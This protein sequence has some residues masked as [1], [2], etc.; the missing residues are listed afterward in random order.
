MKVS[1]LIC[2][3]IAWF[4]SIAPSHSQ[5]FYVAENGNDDNPGTETLPWRTIQWA[6][7]F[8]TQGS[9]VFV[10]AGTYNEKISINVSGS[11][12]SGYITFTRFGNDTVIVDGTNKPGQN[13]IQIDNKSHIKLIGFTIRN[14][15]IPPGSISYGGSGI[16]V[17]GTSNNIILQHNT[18]HN[19]TGEGAMGITIYGTN[20]ASPLE[21]ILVDGNTVYDC[22]PAPSEALTLSGNVT[23]FQVIYNTVHDVNNIGIDFPG[24]FGVCSDSTLDY[25]RNGVCK[26]NTVYN[27]RSLGGYASGIYVDGGSNILVE[28]NVVTSN[29]VGITIGCEVRGRTASFIRVESN[30]VFKNDKRGIS[31]GGFDYPD[32]TGYVRDSWIRFNTLFSNEQIESQEGEL[33]IDYAINCLIEGNI[34]RSDSDNILVLSNIDVR[35]NNVGL[36]YN[37]WFTPGGEN[38]ATFR[39][40]GTTG[41]PYRSF[42]EYR[43]A[44]GGDVHSIFSNPEFVNHSIESPNLH[45]LPSSPAIN[46]GN[47]TFIPSPGQLDIDEEPRVF[48]EQVDIGADEYVP[49]TGIDLDEIE[50]KRF[51]LH[52]NFPNPFNPNTTIA[53]TIPKAVHVTLDVY[54]ILGRKIFSLLD[55]TRD[56]GSY[57]LKFDSSLLSSGV[58]F[59][60]LIAGDY[61]ETKRMMI[62][63]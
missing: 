16:R 47:P 25:P 4:L 38:N 30:F 23:D 63:K 15:H 42:S 40:N 9:F 46:R 20:A 56:M 50:P 32:S 21:H 31:I 24:H 6:A 27:C 22:Q 60:R 14:N 17:T 2:I 10:K 43:N 36:D 26:W 33:L 18:I 44:V 19:I 3:L 12:S 8:A 35:A 1:R 52:Q 51:A 57:L 13:V 54:D 7:N 48:G 11:D 45:I 59:Y 39:M 58:Y 28:G 62:L 34:F 5:S 41:K 37:L 29:D 49:P 53:F 61:A 55:A